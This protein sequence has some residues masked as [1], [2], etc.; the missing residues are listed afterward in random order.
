MPKKKGFRL[1]YLP[2]STT[3]LT[4]SNGDAS[5]GVDE[6]KS[7][8]RA[9]YGPGSRLH[10]CEPPSAPAAPSTGISRPPRGT[11]RQAATE[12]RCS[13]FGVAAAGCARGPG[14]RPGGAVHP[15]TTDLEGTRPPNG[16]VGARSTTTGVGSSM[17]R[18]HRPLGD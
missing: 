13:S 6:E 15:S 14:L 10:H 5:L 16:L 4:G 8:R 2:G 3:V 17:G 9:A 1:K 11:A 18:G 7:C 12:G